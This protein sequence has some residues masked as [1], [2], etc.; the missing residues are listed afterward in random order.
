MEACELFMSMAF[1]AL[2]PDS[3][4]MVVSGRCGRRTRQYES[5]ESH[6]SCTI[7]HGLARG[8]CM[9][10]VVDTERIQ[11]CIWPIPGIQGASLGN[12][13]ALALGSA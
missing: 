2:T 10:A 3:V 6:E 11:N 5:E 4:V 9:E 7:W 12:D 1:S 13:I 8:C